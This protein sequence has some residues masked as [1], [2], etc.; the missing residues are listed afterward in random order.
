MTDRALLRAARALI[1]DQFDVQPGEGVLIAADHRTEMTLIEALS[2]AVVGA[3]ANPVVAV[4]PQLPFQG[5]LA[6]PHIP[7]ALGAAAAASDVWFDCCFPYLAGSH[8]HDAAMK[9][10]RVRYALLATA[11]AASFARLYGGVDFSALM[12]YQAQA[13][14][15][16]AHAV[17]RPKP[18]CA[19]YS[20]AARWR[21]RPFHTNATVRRSRHSPRDGFGV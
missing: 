20:L 14:A 1:C 6:D 17:R 10:G 12:D 13:G 5:A 8:M 15:G 19:T 3:R 2:S 9:K 18:D 21:P 11:G 16:R 4:I 7:D